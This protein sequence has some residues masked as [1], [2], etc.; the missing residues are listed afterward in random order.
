MVFAVGT[1]LILLQIYW[2]YQ[3]VYLQR[4]ETQQKLSR[5]LGDL[6]LVLNQENRDLFHD[7]VITLHDLDVSQVEHSV[8]SFLI[9]HQLDLRV[10]FAIYQDTLGG[11]YKSNS[12]GLKGKLLDS[13]LKSCLSCI[14]SF[15]IV[16][17]TKR[18][19]DESEEDYRQ[20]LMDESTFQYY[21]PVK[22]LKEPAGKALWF[23][24]YVPQAL[25][26]ALQSLIYLF[27][28]NLLLL[29]T[30]LYL[31]YY[32]LGALAKHKKLSQVKD[33]FFNNMTHEFKTPL[34]SIR[35]ASKVLR[36]S[37]D[38]QK[39]EVYHRLIEKESKRLESQVDKLLQ[40]SLLEKEGGQM[41]MQ[42][43]DVQ[44]IIQEVPGRLKLLIEEKAA[45]IHINLNLENPE[46]EGDPDHLSNCFANL[47]E[48]SLKYSPRGVV[49]TI[50]AFEE[51]RQKVLCFRDNG[52]GIAPSFQDQVFERFFRGQKSNQYKGKGFGIGLSYVK[53][54]VEAH[55][56]SIELNKNY[57]KGSEFIIKF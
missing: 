48:N 12:S 27:V 45:V 38:P 54:V 13:D 16:K 40:L 35:L 22:N 2:L 14:I 8:D 56:G 51:S 36:Q 30:L 41:E 15:S 29:G 39:N 47:V 37:K 1:S 10:Y 55:Q 53:S 7:K 31:F 6:A 20:R 21:S 23:S 52:P 3:A 49:I 26:Q 18:G 28:L 5:L 34:G 17:D 32:L 46:L 4:E 33:D 11:V 25:S 50:L 44:Q 24:L 57:K 42:L 19:P 9:A 43:L